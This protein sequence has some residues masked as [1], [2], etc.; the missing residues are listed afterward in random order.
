MKRTVKILELR[1][2][3]EARL[4]SGLLEQK[5]IP[6]MLRS[7][8][9]SAYDGMWQ[10]QTSWGCLDADEENR[11]EILKIYNEMSKPENLINTE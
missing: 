11:E 5:E 7:Y 10:T 1:S 9:D 6:H 3:V 2:E 8:H 4:L